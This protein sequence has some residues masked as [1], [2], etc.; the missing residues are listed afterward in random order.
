MLKTSTMLKPLIADRIPTHILTGF[1]GA[2]KTTLLRHLLAQ[3]PA[4]EVWAVLVNEFGQIGLDGVLLDVDADSG[5]AIREVSGGCLCCTSQLPMQVGLSRLLSQA[6]PQRLFIEP[7][8]LGHPLQL[9][10]QLTE[11]HWQQS[12]ALRAVVTVVDG[13]RLHDVR[14]TDHESFV[15]QTQ[16]ADVLVLSHHTDMNVADQQQWA[17]LLAALPTPERTVYTIDYGALTLAE[18]DLPRRTSRQTRRSLLHRMPTGGVPVVSD[19]AVGQ[20]LPY[21]YVEQGMGQEVGGWRLPAEWVFDRDALLLWL[22][23]LSD[24][25][26]IKGVIQTNHG[27]LS[28]NL[29]PQQMGL[30]SHRG[31]ADNRLEIINAPNADW[32]VREAA[33]LA[34][35]HTA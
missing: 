18:I 31:G 20:A 23:S 34:C 15:A 7:T 17:L 35:I 6:K 19:M 24:W 28:I 13:T 10:E 12:L 14:L 32:T 8:G 3:K 29:I 30:T 4:N 33:L 26:R 16:I 9:V 25:L 1:L 5:I 21:H 27:W 11:P 2:G 22:M